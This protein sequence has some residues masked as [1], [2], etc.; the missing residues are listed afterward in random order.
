M[1]AA[2]SSPK[3][4]AAAAYQIRKFLS[5]DYLVAAHRQYNAV[6]ILRILADNPGPSFTKNIDEKFVETVNRLLRQSRDP[7]VQQIMRETLQHFDTEKKGD[8]NLQPLMAMWKK[9]RTSPMPFTRSYAQ[10]NGHPAVYQQQGQA[11]FNGG[12]PHSNGRPK[13]QLPEPGELAGRIEEAKTSSKLLIQLV[14]ST[15]T[16]EFDSNELIKEFAGK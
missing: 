3:A 9:E 4:A 8:T 16:E 14:Q 7:S 6:M 1:D 10:P 12:Q 11:T 2:E 5:R 13:H 15:P